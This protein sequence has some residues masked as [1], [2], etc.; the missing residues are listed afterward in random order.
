MTEKILSEKT[1]KNCIVFP[2]RHNEFD[3]IF[4]ENSNHILSYSIDFEHPIYQNS[5]NREKLDT[6]TCT[7]TRIGGGGE[8]IFLNLLSNRYGH[9]IV[10]E[11]SRLWWILKYGIEERKFVY[12]KFNDSQL[13][14]YENFIFNLFGLNES[15]L[16]A[17]TKPTKFANLTIPDRAVFLHNGVFDF[18]KE[19][20]K[21]IDFITSKVK[22][23]FNE[24]IYLSRAKVG[25][26]NYYEF[27]EK[28]FEEQ[29]IKK[30]YTIIHPETLPIDKQI[31]LYVGCK[32]LA[33]ISG[34]A[35]HNAIFMPYGAELEIILKTTLFNVWQPLVNSL[36]KLK[37]TEISAFL[38]LTGV[39][40]HSGPF[41]FLPQDLSFNEK[42]LK[43][44]KDDIKGYLI[45]YER[46]LVKQYLHPMPTHEQL[47]DSFEIFK[48]A[49][50]Q[51]DKQLFLDLQTEFRKFEEWVNLYFSHKILAYISLRLRYLPRKLVRNFKR[52][53][54][55]LLK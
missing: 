18:N 17:V 33:A 11:I 30:G 16:V 32:K 13:S 22:P 39:P 26:S 38:E 35:P 20:Q 36:K 34:S 40:Q 15:N 44:I 53:W 8:F 31:A 21:V 55:R 37:V 49:V 10:E 5:T 28:Y 46:M 23:I 47:I 9:F 19:H 2:L 29:Y 42:L 12:A 54:Q 45:E 52:T 51:I 4:D 24:K 48:N 6:I 43:D 7:A 1:L 27:G 25:K 41:L 14:S 3:G 50:K